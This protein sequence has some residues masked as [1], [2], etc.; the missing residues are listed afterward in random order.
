MKSLLIINA[1][2]SSLKFA[3]FNLPLTEDSPSV[4]RGQVD[5]IGAEAK[6]VVKDIDDNKILDTVIPK[7]ADS[8]LEVEHQAALDTLFS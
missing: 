5:G 7:S 2:S 6:F 4:F 3:V 8:N 1:G